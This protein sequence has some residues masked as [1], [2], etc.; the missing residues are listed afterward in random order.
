MA[1]MHAVQFSRIETPRTAGGR[2]R[3]ERFP[4][5]R[6]PVVQEAPSADP[7]RASLPGRLR[8]TEVE[9]MEVQSLPLSSVRGG[10]PPNRSAGV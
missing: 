1:K 2:I 4:P 7:S 9:E 8:Q 6:P 5:S 3:S 10:V